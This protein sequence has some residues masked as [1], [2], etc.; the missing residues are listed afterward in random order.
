M[1]N[2]FDVPSAWRD[3]LMPASYNDA[4]F[5]CEVNSRESG[6]RIV[7]HEFPKKD[8][9]YAEDM[10]RSAREFTVRGYCIVY[11]Y[12][13]EILLFRRDY[14]QARNLLIDALEAEGPGVLQLPTQPPQ[15]VVCARYRITEEERFGGYCV[16]DMTFLEYGID[17]Q[18][19]APSIDT[20]AALNSASKNMRSEAMRVLKPAQVLAI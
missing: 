17:P 16:F 9:P 2:I 5:H 1:A 18:R 14:R 3:Q 6:R 7:Q 12:D 8:L 4:R 20:A 19:W 10:G 15:L 13:S 11:P